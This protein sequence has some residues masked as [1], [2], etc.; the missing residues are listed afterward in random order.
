MSSQAS[1]FEGTPVFISGED[2]VTEYRI[3]SLVVSNKR[4]LIAICDA[5]VDQR[6][7]APNNI[8]LVM[9]RSFDLGRTWTPMRRI[10]AF[11]G[12]E[13][14]CDPCTLV[15]RE[16]GTIWVFYDY[17]VPHDTLPLKRHIMF[18]AIRSDD[19]GETWSDPLDLTS[20][21]VKPD[22]YYLAAAPGMGIQARGGRLI[23][24]TYSVRRD[25]PSQSHMLSSD[26][27]GG[28]WH[29]SA[30]VGGSNDECQVVELS[31]G[32]LM[33]NMRQPRE[34]G[35]RGVAVTADGGETWSDTVDDSA[36]VEPGCQASFVRYTDTRDGDSKNRLLFAN[37][38]YAT[39]RVCMT[40]RLS[41]DEGKTW[42]VSRAIHPGPS[43][44][45]CLTVLPDRAIGLLYERDGYN[46]IAFARFTLEWLTRG[47]DAL[48][49]GGDAVTR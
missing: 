19:D 34:K 24:P 27:H 25:A 7:D 32:T 48:G 37:P 22:W 31:D 20:E 40:V 42:P 12:Q 14:A 36:L 15:D 17:A 1:L 26:D 44:Y 2:G 30:G 11:P 28:T 49:R 35:C 23:A 5:R 18:H 38:A 6:G 4:T 46:Q 16:T 21:L 9:K 43:A 29:L 10:V 13:A 8:D 41:Y 45:S 47:K 33:I 3:P 39:E